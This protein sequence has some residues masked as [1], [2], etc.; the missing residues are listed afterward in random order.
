MGAFAPSPKAAT[1]VAT[2]SVA[3]PV[4]RPSAA[5]VVTRPQYAPVVGT[6]SATTYEAGT[7]Q[8]TTVPPTAAPA[9]A[10]PAAAAA[11]AAPVGAAGTLL[12][13]Q[14]LVRRFV[15]GGTAKFFGV[16]AE[17][18][19]SSRLVWNERRMRLATKR[20][21]GVKEEYQYGEGSSRMRSD[22][23][24]TSELEGDI[25]V[26]KIKKPPMNKDS[27]SSLTGQ[28][29]SW[30][31]NVRKQGTISSLGIRNITEKRTNDVIFALPPQSLD[32]LQELN[33]FF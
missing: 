22:H 24:I 20:F 19:E 13:W 1:S 7:A 18:E 33:P 31:L 5:A 23:H 6:Q 2:S 8:T 14:D 11:A 26:L 28:G 29:I 25:M 3:A 21:G 15:V 32:N 16:D 4:V 12:L 27:I 10:P 30:L 17:T 9:V